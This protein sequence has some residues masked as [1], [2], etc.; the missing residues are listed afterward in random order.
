MKPLASHFSYL[1]P[2][3]FASLLALAF[4]APSFAANPDNKVEFK[5]EGKVVRAFSVDRLR[6]I[7]LERA[8]E[9]FEPHERRNRVYR[10]L[11][12]RA[13]FAEVFGRDWE[14]ARE[15][16][17]TAIDGYQPSVPVKKFLH[18]DGYFAFANENR[19]P[20]TLTNKLQ[21]NEVVPLGPLY[22]VWNNIGSKELLEAGAS[23]MPYQIK[24]IELKMKGAFPNMIPP[25]GSS[26]QVQRGFEHFRR[27][28]AACHTINGEGGGKAPELNYPE[29]I[30][31]Y[32]KPEYLKRW[33]LAPQTIR[34]NTMMPG[35]GEEISNR[36]QVAAEIIAYLKTMSRA[37]RAPSE[38]PGDISR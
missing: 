6:A 14:K 4:P 35:L 22:L 15:I 20:F 34:Y 8:L 21:N 2:L 5:K 37:K 28:C 17:F 12:A 1:P 10:V 3:V 25:S 13:V 7:A 27:H 24:T 9:V 31:E 16:V 33:I 23:D 19:E 26:K 18:H 30:V 38:N 29:S 11:P 36:E 32:I